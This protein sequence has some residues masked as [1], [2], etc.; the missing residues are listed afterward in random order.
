MNLLK[1]QV[2]R[3]KI[4]ASK[5]VDLGVEKTLAQEVVR[6]PVIN[7]SLPVPRFNADDTVP[8]NHDI[9]RISGAG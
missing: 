6:P 9:D 7:A 2:F 1:V 5:P 3:V 8:F 4:D